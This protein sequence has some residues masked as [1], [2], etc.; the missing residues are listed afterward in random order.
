VKFH[1]PKCQRPLKAKREMMGRRVRCPT[2]G[3]TMRIFEKKEWL[4]RMLYRSAN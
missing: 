4:G 2:C 1:C 3:K